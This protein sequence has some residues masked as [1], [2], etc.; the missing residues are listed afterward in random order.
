[1]KSYRWLQKKRKE[2]FDP[3]RGSI[4]WGNTFL[5][6]FDSFGV[7]VTANEKNI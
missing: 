4:H 7:G 1:M 6:R 5:M 3:L 2:I